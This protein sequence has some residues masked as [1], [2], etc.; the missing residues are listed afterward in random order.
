[1]T[2]PPLFKLR[3]AFVALYGCLAL[4]ASMLIAL[5]YVDATLFLK[6]VM[7]LSGVG[8]VGFGG[9]LLW[10]TRLWLTGHKE[11]P[12]DERLQALRNRSY[13]YAYEVMTAAILTGFFYSAGAHKLG[14]WV[15]SW[16]ILMVVYPVLLLVLLTLPSFVATWTEP[17]ILEEDVAG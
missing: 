16:D 9:F 13:R 5:T 12:L 11:A 1:M 3:F 6:A 7:V 15:P 8:V 17:P 10:G 14:W 4:L 2:Y